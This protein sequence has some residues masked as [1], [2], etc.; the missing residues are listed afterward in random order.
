MN[1]YLSIIS[2]QMSGG[3]VIKLG[4]MSPEAWG[5]RRHSSLRVTLA[6]SPSKLV[7]IDIIFDLKLSYH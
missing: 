6:V 5:L 2:Y 7:T 1:Q 3:S 4:A